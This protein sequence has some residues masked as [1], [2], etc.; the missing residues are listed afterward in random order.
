MNTRNILLILAVALLPGFAQV[1]GEPGGQI[2]YNQVGYMNQM[3][4]MLLV[5]A[6]VDEVAI[7]DGDGK[8]VLKVRPAPALFWD[9]SG[10][11]VRKVD[12]S[13]IT[14][15][16]KYT[17]Q[18]K[19]IAEKPVINIA[20]KPYHKLTRSVMKAFYLSRLGMPI[21]EVYAGAWAR[22]AA[23]PDTTVY[24]HPSAAGPGR[25]AGSVIQSPGGWYDAGDYN[26]Y[27]VNSAITTYTLMKAVEDYPG[28]YRSL[29]LNI[30]ESRKGVP[31][32]LAEAV[33][34]YKWMLTM[35]DP[36]DG[37]VYHKL[38]NKQFDGVVMPQ[39]AQKERFVVMKT[40][41]AALDLAAVA[42]HAS[43]TLAPYGKA[44]PGLA[45]KSLEQSE[46]AWK[47][48]KQHPELHYKQPEDVKTGE[49]GDKNLKDEWF[50]AAAELY[51]A[52]GKKEYEDAVV[53]YYQKPATPEWAIV[54]GLGF[55]SLLSAYDKLPASIRQTNLREDFLAHVDELVRASETS[56]FGV[57]IRKFV[58]G[59]N[60][61]VANEGMLKLFAFQLTSAQKYL[62]S[63]VSDLDYL[64]GRNATG[65]C[66][67]TGYGQRQVMHIHHRPSQADGIPD[68]WPGFLAGGPNLDTFADCPE[69]KTRPKLPAT[70]YVDMDCSYS[71]NEVAINWNAPMAYLC[72]GFDA[73]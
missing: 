47:W 21:E 70:S 63:A 17:V 12:F 55:M 56:P 50:W 29:N 45:S 58:W 57:S 65:Y 72:G 67:V 15:P 49:Y 71:T 64:M 44:Y 62:S 68:P 14:V 39:D 52:T 9:A 13:A 38:T 27:I 26:K 33:Y 37:G 51:L 61:Y 35:Q 73:R 8:E 30:P 53:T 34:N 24:I 59:S 32:L 5:P 4:K 46:K 10:T 11:S 69:D 25:P 42:A 3:P 20:S 1:P 41:A 66:F 31:D 23:H 7:L 43:R 16:G 28:F 36:S 18:A 54:H 22:P 60:S 48:A 19:G 2:L 40:T 6:H